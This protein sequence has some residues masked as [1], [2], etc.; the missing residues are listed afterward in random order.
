MTTRERA[1][2]VVAAIDR[3]GLHAASAAG[4]PALESLVAAALD[5]AVAAE[6][7][8]CARIVWG[9]FR[10]DRDP[11]IPAHGVGCEHLIEAAIRSGIDV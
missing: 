1:A 3:A 5:A 6:R 2:R 11:G 8:R 10:A 7:E 9:H 4:A